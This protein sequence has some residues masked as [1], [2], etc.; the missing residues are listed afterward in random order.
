[1]SSNLVKA[2]K[3][4]REGKFTLAIDLYQRELPLAQGPLINIIKSNLSTA[5]KHLAGNPSATLN[6]SRDINFSNST[7]KDQQ[8]QRTGKH[9]KKDLNLVRASDYFDSQWYINSYCDSQ[10]LADGFDPVID[11]LDRCVIEQLNPSQDFDTKY[12]L[13]TYPDIKKNTLNPLLHFL[14][15]GKKE[16]RRAKP[17]LAKQIPDENGNLR[18]PNRR[19][20]NQRQFQSLSFNRDHYWYRD[21]SVE[22]YLTS[23]TSQEVLPSGLRRLLVIAHDF[24]LSTG[25]SRPISHYLNAM[26]QLGGYELT[27]IELAKGAEGKSVAIDL[28]AH[29]FV[30]INSYAPFINNPGL[31]TLAAKTAASNHGKL[32]I[33]LHETDWGFDKFESDYPDLYKE[34]RD[35]AKLFPFLLVSNMQAEIIKRRFSASRCYVVYNTTTIES[36]SQVKSES[37]T[38]RF[39]KNRGRIKIVMA[40]TL[41]TRKGVNLFSDVADFAKDSGLNWEFVWAG[42]EA[43]KNI[44]KSSNVNYVGNLNQKDL[45]RLLEGSDL[46]FLSSVDDPFPL[47]VLESMQLKKRVVVFKNSGISEVI[48]GVAGTAIYAT[49]EVHA[50]ITAINKALAE[51]IDLVKYTELNEMLGLHAFMDR[52]NSAISNIRGAMPSP[53]R[54]PNRKIAVHLHL[55]YLDLWLEMRSYLNNLKGLNADI[56][57]TISQ[58]APENQVASIVSHITA[59]FPKAIILHCENRGMDVGPFIQVLSHITRN[60]KSYDYL[61][62]IHT[63]KSLQASGEQIGAEWRRDLLDGLAATPTLVD[64]ILSLFESDMN[65]GLIGPQN[66]IISK[67]KRDAELGVNANLYNMKLL[68]DKFRLTIKNDQRF[69]RGT[70]F[71]SRFD[72]IASTITDSGL[73]INDF[74]NGHQIDESMAHAME[75]LLPAIIEHKDLRI[76]AFDRQLPRSIVGLKGRHADKDIYI[77]A[78]GASCDYLDPS[79]F[80]NKIVIGVNRVFRK[81]R[82][83]YVVMKEY[84][85]VSWIEELEKSKSIPIVSKWDSGN[86]QQGKQRL[87]SDYFRNPEC[88]YYDHLENMREVVDL[89]VIGDDTGKM[90]VSY[91]SITTAMH[92]AAWLGASNILLVGHDCGTLDNRETFEGYYDANTITPWKAPSEYRAWLGKI[93]DQSIMVRNKIASVFGV[94]I[95]SVNPFINFGLEGHVYGK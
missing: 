21:R 6:D 1:M 61:L 89:S 52:M 58:D 41:Q 94:N 80:D 5:K 82:C 90:V 20:G 63:K 60:N 39:T 95:C 75:R 79:F 74:E 53:R 11:F 77:I 29:D 73:S 54:Y 3:A 38:N 24:Q 91:S 14:K 7:Y 32:A 46:F 25:V 49:H 26:S 17:P 81:F 35:C 45:T 23:T 43:D 42:W 30:I 4:L 34:F 37:A 47:S 71:W 31:L 92:F 9:K 87:N 62:K 51:E 64:R 19:P 2:N 22:D 76:H 50:A 15:S 65:I 69:V 57:V 33:Y 56:Y 16:G 55:Y 48:Q 18:I 27:S 13:E 86:I 83:D 70:M 10:L 59:A 68:A 93:E 84:G 28:D 78:A 88:F 40:G 67:T 12:Y 36:F 66:M 72:E 8:V 44:R 85:G